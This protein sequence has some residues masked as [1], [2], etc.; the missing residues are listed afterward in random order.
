MDN[1]ADMNQQA[2]EAPKT[3]KEGSAG[4]TVAIIVIILILIAGGYYYFTVGINP[5]QSPATGD[6]AATASDVAALNE[7]GTSDALGDIEADLNATDLSGLDDASAGFESEL[8][9]Q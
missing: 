5:A 2:P 3:K 1:N 9:P 4:S 8:Q 7:Q 6:E